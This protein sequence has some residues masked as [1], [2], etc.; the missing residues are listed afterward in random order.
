MM[1]NL[2]PD[3]PNPT[4]GP[5]RQR[6]QARFRKARE[7]AA[8]K[9]RGFHPLEVWVP[10]WGVA[11]IRHLEALLQEGLLTNPLITQKAI[12]TMIKDTSMLSTL[13]QQAPEA[14]NGSLRLTQQDDVLTVIV[15]DKEH[16]PVSLAVGG[17]QIL[18]MN[19]LWKISEVSDPAAMNMAMMKTNVSMPLSSFAIVGDE[20]VLFGALSV[21]SGA[22]EIIEE[23]YTLVSNTEAAYEAFAKELRDAA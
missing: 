20:Y 12:M 6:A 15:D 17:G 4:T 18:A 2:V 10:S 14:L 5:A 11:H 9:A 16:I 3:S 23:I 8:K 1:S 7:R 13:L 21:A 22:A 19:A